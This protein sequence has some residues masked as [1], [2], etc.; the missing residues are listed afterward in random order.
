H[1]EPRRRRPAFVPAQD[2]RGAQA[3][4][5]LAV[6]ERLPVRRLQRPALPDVQLQR[7][8]LPLN[9]SRPGSRRD[10]RPVL[11]GVPWEERY[12]AESMSRPDPDVQDVSPGLF[13]GCAYGSPA[14]ALPRC[15]RR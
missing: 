4:V 7:L 13:I 11:R 9:G 12:C 15:G 5:R 3:E 1:P 2:A 6:A 14:V 10:M 8:T